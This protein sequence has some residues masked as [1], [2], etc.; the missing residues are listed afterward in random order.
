[1]QVAT[2][3]PGEEDVKD[4]VVEH[5]CLSTLEFSHVSPVV[6]LQWLP[7]WEVTAKGALSM[8]SEVVGCSFF[9][10]CSLDGKLNFWDCRLDHQ[11]S[12]KRKNDGVPRRSRTPK[13]IPLHSVLA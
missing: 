12:K 6:Q 5:K 8:H 1:M 2:G 11:R 13:L 7:G 10:T 4:T 9:V 3:S